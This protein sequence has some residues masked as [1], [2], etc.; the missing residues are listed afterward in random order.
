MSLVGVI[1]SIAFTFLTFVIYILTWRY[2][3]SDQNIIML[4]LCGSLVLSYLIFISAVEETGNEGLCIGI[5]ILIHYL[6]LVTFFSMLGMGVYYFI[7]ITVTYYAMYVANNFK[8]KSRLRWFLLGVWGIPAIITAT[9]LG[10]FN[11][12][13]Y[14]QKFYCWLSMESGSLYMFIIPVCFIIVLNLL[15]IGSLIRVLCASSIMTKSS[16]QKKATSA[17]RSLGTLIPVLG[18]T[19]LFGILAVNE[20]AEMFQ[21]IFVIA[22]SLQGLFIFVSHVLLNKKV[23]QGLRNKYPAFST[24][25]SFTEESKKETTSVSRSQS[26]SRSD[27]QTL[28]TKKKGWI[29]R[30]HG[31]KSAVNNKVKKSESYLTEKTVST[32]CSTSDL[33]E[34]NSVNSENELTSHTLELILEEGRTESRFPFSFNLNPWKKKYNVT[35]M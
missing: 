15:I 21:Y 31:I 33:N 27:T 32:D 16:L 5:T 8:S 1:I 4:T 28:K 22:N 29:A 24:L 9:T 19:W 18:V 26:T 23:M 10:A 30:F 13:D 7:S 2:V 6:F 35:E 12:K 20:K 3:K 14:H 34:K 25:M 17:V 11:G